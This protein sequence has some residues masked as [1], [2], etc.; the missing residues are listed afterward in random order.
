[1]KK[2]KLILTLLCSMVLL[3]QPVLLTGCAGHLATNT[4]YGDDIYLY[5]AEKATNDGYK[6]LD[7]FLKWEER[8]R[9]VLPPE[10]SRAMDR[11]RVGMEQW[12]NSAYA[13][14][15][16]Y[17]ANKT[18]ENRSKL[19]SALNLIETAITEAIGYFDTYEIASP[20]GPGVPVEG[21][22]Q[23]APR[24][25]SQATPQ[26]PQPAQLR[27]PSGKPFKSVFDEPNI[28]NKGSRTNN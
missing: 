28:E 10:V 13:M 8:S 1:M 26:R 4:V 9:A 2:V 18:A 19:D 12:F 23:A 5:R 11:I 7:T 14:R 3:S 21:P 6:L 17:V 24:R 25:Q 15:D 22:P 16:A 20:S 27:T